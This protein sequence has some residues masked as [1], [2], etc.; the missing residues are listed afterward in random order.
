MSRGDA[1]EARVKQRT[2]RRVLMAILL[3]AGLLLLVLVAMRI[4]VAGRA[5]SLQARIEG[6]RRATEAA[7]QARAAD[8]ERY[9]SSGKR[10]RS[11]RLDGPAMTR[12]MAG[13]HGHKI[14]ES[15]SAWRI[16]FRDGRAVVEGVVNLKRY[17]AEM[18]FQQPSSLAGLSGQEVPFSFNGRLVAEAGQGRF[19]VDEVTILGLPLPL[20]MVDRVAGTE[21]GEESVLVQRFALPAGIEQAVIE[22]DGMVINGTSAGP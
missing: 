10:S 13:R 3:L 19:T 14:P 1:V 2:G 22:D 9:L 12:F 16:V 4:T 5:S 11:F 7:A 8:F 17:L 15:V 6:E 21:D 18:G 20:E